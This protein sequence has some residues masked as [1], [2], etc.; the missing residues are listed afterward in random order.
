MLINK[1]AT[2][3]TYDCYKLANKLP[4]ILINIMFPKYYK[5][6]HKKTFQLSYILLYNNT[7]FI[8]TIQLNSSD[9]ELHCCE[10]NLA[11]MWT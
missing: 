3:N 8:L 7:N 11:D 6:E 5:R 2:S 1:P 10:Q 4:L 9:I